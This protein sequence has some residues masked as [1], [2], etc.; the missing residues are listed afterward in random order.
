LPDI[1]CSLG[2]SQ[3]KKL[4]QFKVRRNEI[5]SKYDSRLRSIEWIKLPVCREYVSPNWHLYPIRVP[6]EIRLELFKYLLSNGIGVQV[7]YIPAY[8]HPVFQIPPSAYDEF[9]NSEKF[10]KSEISLPIHLELSEKDQEKICSL[11][12]VF[13]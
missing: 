4:N 9:P 8:R 11:I 10:Y 5:F 1:L 2:I 7:N 6:T 12:E 13:S 3:S